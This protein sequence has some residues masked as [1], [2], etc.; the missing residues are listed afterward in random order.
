MSPSSNT[1]NAPG[2][3]NKQESDPATTASIAALD[4]TTV[5]LA[6]I[7]RAGD[8]TDIVGLRHFLHAGPPIE[9]AD[10]TGPMR[11]ALIGGLLF[12]GEAQDEHDAAAIIDSGELTISP[13][14]DAGA[15]GAMAGVITPNMPVVVATSGD[16]RTF[17][18]LNEGTGGAVRYGS[19]DAATIDRLRW[20]AGVLA[21]ALDTA[22]QAS[23]PIDL[24]ALVAEGLRRGDDCHNRLVATTANL[25]NLLAPALVREVPRDD[26]AETMSVI[27]GNGHFALP[28]AITMAKALTLSAADVP[29]SPVVT[30]MSANGREFAI[31]VSGT[32]DRWFT[33]PSPVGTPQLVPGLTLADVNPTMGDSMIAETAGF[34][35]FAMSAA[36]AIMSFVGGTAA[37]GVE[38]VE[39]MRSITA[40]TS[41]RFLLPNEDHRGTPVGIDV[42]R[43]ARSGIAPVINNGLA[44]RE[45]GRGR[46]GAGITRVPI[47]CFTAASGALAAEADRS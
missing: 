11:G 4:A 31:R 41:S 27:A 40:A 38:I 15:L 16:C 20:I 35:A 18:P 25:L 8:M 7:S 46:A 2:Q 5:E 9:V 43:V 28:F 32:G 34:G 45:I 39:E 14:H 12:E 23:D 30:A 42:H 26:A 24:V 44:H 21:P 37:E 1:D 17:S 19:F 47:E 6:G 3:T 13:C 22:I 33:A 36:P 10:V 29:G